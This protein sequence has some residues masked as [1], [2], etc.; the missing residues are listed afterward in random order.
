MIGG[1]GIDPGW[2]WLYALLAAASLVVVIV[3]AV[4]ALRADVGPRG[5]GRSDARR[6]LDEKFAR[7][8]ISAEQYRERMAELGDQP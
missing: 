1:P 4:R 3:W 6:I 2:F 5:A 7:G 8:E